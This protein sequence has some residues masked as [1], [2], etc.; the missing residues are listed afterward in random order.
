MLQKQRTNAAAIEEMEERDR[1]L[2]SAYRRMKAELDQ[3]IETLTEQERAIV[4]EACKLPGLDALEQEIQTVEARLG[5]MSEGNPGA[6]R[7]YEKREEDIARAREKLEQYTST[8]EEAKEQITEIRQQWEP[9][10]DKLIRKI[11]DAFAHNFSQIGCAGEVEVFKDEEDFDNWS[12]QIS[13]RF[14]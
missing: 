10:L 8:L 13:V 4:A 3:V 5:L 1:T 7:A 11:S 9:E 14:R 6:I 12:I 2:R